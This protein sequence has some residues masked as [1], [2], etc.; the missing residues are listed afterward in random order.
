MALGGL[1][2]YAAYA[3]GIGLIDALART[4]AWGVAMGSLLGMSANYVS[5]RRVIQGGP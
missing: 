5:A 2:N 1:L 4:P 3:L